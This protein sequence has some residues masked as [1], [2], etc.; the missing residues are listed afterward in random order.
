MSF[1]IR[2]IPCPRNL[3]EIPQPPETLYVRGKMPPEDVKY[4]AVVGSRDCT[5]YAKNVIDHLLTGLQGHNICIVS[6]L[7]LGVDGYAHEASLTHK[8]HTIAVPG[9]GIADDV[10]YPKTHRPLAARILS[11][12]GALL[13][14]FEP[15][16]PATKWSF[17]KRNRIMAGLADAVIL[18]ESAEKSGTL[19]TARL[20]ADFNRD[21][22]VVPGDI[23]SK[24]SA[25]VHQFLKLGAV[26]ITCAEDILDTLSFDRKLLP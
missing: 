9:S 3:A 18:I 10:L 19:I 4:L 24:N 20:A 14:E 23:F 15:D 13:S 1:P 11:S 12:G 16:F 26:P 7:A 17:P 2:T 25:G 22:L 6:G 21:V 5:P 8:L